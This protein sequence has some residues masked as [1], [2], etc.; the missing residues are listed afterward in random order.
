ME[1]SFNKTYFDVKIFDPL[2]KN[3]PA[4]SSEAYKYHESTKKNKNE[5]GINDVDKATFCP[6]VFACT[7]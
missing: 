6:F 7:V 3:C 5:Q 2:A 4:S 1:S